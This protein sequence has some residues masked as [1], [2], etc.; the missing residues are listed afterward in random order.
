M[1]GFPALTPEGAAGRAS[2]PRRPRGAHR[3]ARR[4]S[5]IHAALH[6]RRRAEARRPIWR[7]ATSAFTR[8]FRRPGTSC[9]RWKQSM[10][11]A[12]F[13][14]T[15]VRT[16]RRASRN[17]TATPRGRWEGD[18][19]V[20][21]TTNFSPKSNF[22]G[23]AENLHLVERFTRVASRHDQLRDHARRSDDVDEAVDGGSSPLQADREHALRV[24]VSRGE[25][26]TMAGI[27][28]G[29]RAQEKAAE[30]AR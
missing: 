10:T 29:G 27:L 15:S 5:A 1:G 6:Y 9:L 18:T 11:R 28:A 3:P 23:S 30:T 7:R 13:R 21:D 2:R 24:R 19:L 12:S 14:S 8:F 26:R 4:I 20:V 16:F 17:G 25:Q 22:M